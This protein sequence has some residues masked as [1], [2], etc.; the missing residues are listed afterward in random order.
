MYPHRAAASASGQCGELRGALLPRRADPKAPTHAMSGDLQEYGE[1]D[2]SRWDSAVCQGR[3]GRV[4]PQVS[5]PWDV[6]LAGGEHH[7]YLLDMHSG[8]KEAK[9][10]TAGWGASW[11]SGLKPNV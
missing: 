2:R 7:I 1:A 11:N 9:P 3:A 10:E 6:I 5:G 8:R 4:K